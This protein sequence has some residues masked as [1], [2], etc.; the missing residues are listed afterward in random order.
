MNILKALLLVAA[1]SLSVW[2][3]RAREE[4]TPAKG[5]VLLFETMEH[6]FG[7][8]KQ[9][10]GDVSCEFRFTNTGT[11][12]LVIVDAQTSCTCT[13][14]SYS[15]KPVPPGGKGTIKITYDPR[16]KETGVFYKAIQIYS[17]AGGGRQA[18][19]IRG[20]SVE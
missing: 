17:N 19:V 4:K 7:D 11:A 12:P 15:R 5:A 16:K 2:T 1:A 20:R 8:I 14:A 10:G 9:K 18:V 6:D 3:V 13:K